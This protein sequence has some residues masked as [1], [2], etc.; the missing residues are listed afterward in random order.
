MSTSMDEGVEPEDEFVPPDREGQPDRP[1]EELPEEA[2]ER[3]EEAV[4]RASE[5]LDRVE[6]PDVNVARIEGSSYAEVRIKI[7]DREVVEAVIPGGTESTVR[8]VGS[9]TNITVDGEVIIT[10]NGEEVLDTINISPGPPIQRDVVEPIIAIREEEPRE[11]TVSRAINF[12]V[13][14]PAETATGL[15]LAAI[16]L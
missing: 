3:A 15:G 1:P 9:I 8:Y 4:E 10:V 16:L 2:A 5:V 12:A 14:N 13:E 11:S 6:T 7:D